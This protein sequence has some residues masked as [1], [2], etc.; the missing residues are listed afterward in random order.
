MCKRAV[1]T[2]I[3]V[4]IALSL[5][6]GISRAATT[7]TATANARLVGVDFTVTPAVAFDQLID[8]G[9]SVAQAQIDSLGVTRA[10]ASTPYPSNSVVLLPGLIAGI[11]NGATSE[12]IP[13][14]PLIAASNETTSADHRQLGTIALDALSETGDSRGTITDGATRAVARTTAKDERV[15]AHAETSVSSLQLTSALTLEGVRT[16]A[17]ATRNAGGKISTTSSFEVAAL[18]ILGQRFAVTPKTFKLLAQALNALAKQ[19]TTIEFIPAIAT[20]DG[21][22]SAGLRITSLFDVPAE[23][24]SG[25][26]EARARVTLGLASAS[27]SNRTLSGLD[28]SPILDTAT[29]EPVVSDL[30]TSLPALVA[31]PDLGAAPTLRPLVPATRTHPLPVSDSLGSFYVVLVLAAAVGVGLVNL[32]RHLGVRSP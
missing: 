14:Y 17:D 7:Y 1:V 11:S 31:S 20:A 25:L 26:Q 28:S 2:T 9:V 22:T 27:V 32:I 19:G 8:A 21:I 13:D 6:P 30:V 4:A 23:V 15:V 24:A 10:F 5:L 12:L 16:V 3:G 29:A 18:T